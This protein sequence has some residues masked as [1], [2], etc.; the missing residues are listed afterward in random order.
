MR[1]LDVV[2]LG[3]KGRGQGDEEGVQ[4]PFAWIGA[5]AWVEAGTTLTLDDHHIHRPNVA[6]GVRRGSVV[7]RQNQMCVCRLQFKF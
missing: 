1:R 2:P 6:P 4:A 3:N 7:W 5:G